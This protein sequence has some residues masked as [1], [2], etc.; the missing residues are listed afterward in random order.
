MTD[1]FKRAHRLDGNPGSSAH[2]LS[3]GPGQR[4]R[5]LEHDCE[6]N[7]I[8]KCVSLLP[9]GRPLDARATSGTSLLYFLITALQR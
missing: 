2:R 6:R 1:D 5:T 7:R 3:R 9:V 8:V 4:S